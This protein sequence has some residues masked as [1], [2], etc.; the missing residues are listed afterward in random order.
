MSL[1]LPGGIGLTDLRVYDWPG[2]DGLAGGSPHVHLAS[3]ECYVVVKGVGSIETL[4][5]GGVHD[6]ELTPGV[7]TWFEPGTV[8]R[9]V[10]GSGDLRVL[11]AM[12]NS[13][14]PEAGDAVMTFPPEH[15][16]D[17]D[18]Y[19]AAAS[20]GLPDGG[21]D[22]ES[23]RV[24]RDLA[25]EGYAPLRAALLAG[26]RAPFEAFLERARTIVE[27]RLSAWARIVHDG[28]VAQAR[29]AVV[30]IDDLAAGGISRLLEAQVRTLEPPGTRYGMCGVLRAYSVE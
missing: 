13:G 14:L 12:S 26:D 7:V 21:T 10:N 28:P 30:R 24:R 8:H 23:V 17:L 15:L 27:T 22:V 5:A 19:A 6:V 11:V 20:V 2:A 4:T 16:V 25:W 3:T 29:D 18:A 1:S 9:V